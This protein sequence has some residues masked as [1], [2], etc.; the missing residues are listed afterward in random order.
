[1]EFSDVLAGF[2]DVTISEI[3]SWS[4]GEEEDAKSQDQGPGETDADR[5][6]P[7]SGVGDG[8]C[9]EVDEVGEENTD[10]DK[11]L[12]AAVIVSLELKSRIAITYQT[13]AP[14]M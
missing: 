3:E 7:G 13:I 5:D 8:L 14:R 9:A 6:T 12:V 11:E 10:C 1:M 2:I 4:L